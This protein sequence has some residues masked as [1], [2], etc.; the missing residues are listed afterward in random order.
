MMASAATY[1]I[2]TC[3]LDEGKNKNRNIKEVTPCETT[4]PVTPVKESKIDDQDFK[5]QNLEK[6]SSL[7]P[8][9]ISSCSDK[10]KQVVTPL[11]II[12]AGI[13]GEEDDNKTLT[14]KSH[15][16]MSVIGRRSVMEDAV[17]MVL[18]VAVGESGSYD[19]FAVYDGHGGARVANA[20]RY[21]MHQLVAK[22]VE[23][24]ERVG[25]GKGLEYWEKL[26]GACFE[27]MDEELVIHNEGGGGEVEIG[28]EALS[29]KSMGSTAVVVM[30]GKEEVVVANCG[31]SRA[32][33][34]RGGLVVPLSHD[35]KPDRPDERERVEAAGG[36]IINWNGSRVQGVLATSRSIGDHYLKPFVISEPEVTVSERT[37][38]DEFVVIAT[39]GLWDV[40]TNETACKVVKRLFDGQLKRRLP[41]EFSGNCSA[42]AAAKLAKLAMARGSRDNISVIV[43]QLKKS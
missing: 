25:G 38:S 37:E 2:N 4:K 30:V 34:C 16:M 27:K 22:E 35:H 24:G 23:K 11:G 17:T 7:L 40:V 39:D 33:M 13:D 5:H 43:V 41:D 19:F 20:C 29:I 18:G 28:K 36:R 10:G 8:P 21:R 32:V 1:S 12:E 15:G 31:D 26:M 42:E 6:Y 9:S 14:C 3:F